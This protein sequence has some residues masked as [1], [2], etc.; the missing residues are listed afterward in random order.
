MEASAGPG[1]TL[2]VPGDFSSAAFWMVAAAALP[3]STVTIEQVGLNPSRIALIEVLRRFGA[4]VD[5]QP[6][7]VAAGEPLG[8]IVV[9]A[10]RLGSLEIAPG[11]VPWPH[12]RTPCDLGSRGT[13]RV[14]HRAGCRRT[15]REGE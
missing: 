1:Q 15:A 2:P 5:V 3:G 13:R 14:G 12:R 10:D 4:R 6:M 9:T 7:A 11:E 8:T